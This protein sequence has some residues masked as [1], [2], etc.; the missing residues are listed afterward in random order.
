MKDRNPFLPFS[1]A[2]KVTPP[3]PEELPAPNGDTGEPWG[4]LDVADLPEAYGVDEVTILWRDP[5]SMFAHWEVTAHGFSSAQRVL[6]Q[7][8]AL[9]LRL[10]SGGAYTDEP[11]P[12]AV[13]RGYLRAPRPGARV[14][15]AVGVRSQEGVF[16]AIAW[17]PEVALPPEDV[18]PE[19]TVT[20][21]TVAPAELGPP[22]I[23]ALS[24]ASLPDLRPPFEPPFADAPAPAV[25][26]PSPTS[27]T[28]PPQ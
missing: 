7:S 13:G 10:E 1:P 28:R 25:T 6:G 4:M 23:V 22:R 17:A 5:H 21:M 19:G 12:R 27:P 9:V 11:I 14:R 18:A 15:G 20:W 8:G 2:P 16:V 24:G 26:S 3:P